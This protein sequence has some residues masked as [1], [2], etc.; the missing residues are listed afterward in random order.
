MIAN[1]LNFA[2]VNI[3]RLDEQIERVDLWIEEKK[4]E[5]MHD[6]LKF[7]GIALISFQTE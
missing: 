1:K 7:S 6:S 2:D 3:I 4:L 5:I